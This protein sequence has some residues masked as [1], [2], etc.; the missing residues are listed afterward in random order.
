LRAE[1]ESAVIAAPAHTLVVRTRRAGDRVEEGGREMSLKRFL[2]RHRIPATE[3]AGLP[4]VA[5][6][7]RVLWI[8]GRSQ[9]LARTGGVG[10]VRLSLERTA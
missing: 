6:G 9:A 5:S 1:P 3:R 10:S 2:M 8:P 7:S 4:L